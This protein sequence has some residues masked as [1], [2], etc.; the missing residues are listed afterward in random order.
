[1]SKSSVINHEF[2]EEFQQLCDEF[3]KSLK[4]I[5]KKSIKKLCS[6]WLKRLVHCKDSERSLRSSY[7]RL[8]LKQM[9][10]NLIEDPFSNNPDSKYTLKPLTKRKRRMQV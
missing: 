1:M 8:L 7:L 6:A 10:A 2:D 3:V 9:K 4:N 5:K